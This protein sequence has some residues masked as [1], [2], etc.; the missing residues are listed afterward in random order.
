[1][2]R[3]LVFLLDHPGGVP[4]ARYRKPPINLGS[5]AAERNHRV[6]FNAGLIE[7]VQHPTKL[8]FALTEKGK[9][10]AELLKEIEKIVNEAST[11]R[12]S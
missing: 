3:M 11:A 2:C 4:R 9:R 5:R 1:M 6:L 10:V 7:S 8:L 12:T